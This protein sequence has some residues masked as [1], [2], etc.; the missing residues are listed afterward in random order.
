[1][2]NLNQNKAHIIFVVDT[3][4]SMAGSRFESTL[5][6][7]HEILNGLEFPNVLSIAYSLITFSNS[8]VVIEEH[9]GEISIPISSIQTENG[10]S[11]LHVAYTKSCEIS[12]LYKEPTWIILFSDFGISSLSSDNCSYPYILGKIALNVGRNIPMNHSFNDF[13]IFGN[14]ENQLNELCKKISNELK[15]LASNIHFSF[16]ERNT[17]ETHHSSFNEQ[18]SGFGEEDDVWNENFE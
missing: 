8:Y 3:S 6:A 10:L 1:M 11:N 14:T 4:R 5:E 17:D 7:L 16:D 15:A 13:T 12:G 2:N 18:N 9:V